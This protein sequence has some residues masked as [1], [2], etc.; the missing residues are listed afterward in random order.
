MCNLMSVVCY[1]AHVAANDHTRQMER[2]MGVWVSGVS[3]T[4]QGIGKLKEKGPPK[5][6][7]DISGFAH[8]VPSAAP[9]RWWH[10]QHRVENSS[11]GW[12]SV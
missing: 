9:A 10:P 6:R 3:E 2:W 8:L 12:M 7:V 11:C 5:S 4:L 1:P